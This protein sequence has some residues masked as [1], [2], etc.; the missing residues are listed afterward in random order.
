MLT[1][2]ASSMMD[3]PAGITALSNRNLEQKRCTL[4]TYTVHASVSVSSCCMRSLMPL[5]AL[6]V[7]VRHSRSS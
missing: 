3:V 4:P 7:K 6:L 5:A 1:A 2:S